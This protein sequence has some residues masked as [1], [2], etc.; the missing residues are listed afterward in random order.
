MKN[1]LKKSLSLLMAVLMILSCWVWVAPE[2]ASAAGTYSVSFDFYVENQATD[3]GHIYLYYHPW[4]ADGSGIDTNQRVKYEGTETNSCF[5]EENKTYVTYD[6]P[7]VDG[8]PCEFF[9]KVNHRAAQDEIVKFLRLRINGKLVADYSGMPWQI[10]DNDGGSETI[11][12]EHTQGDKNNK[13]KEWNTPYFKTLT[14]IDA[15]G[16]TVGKYPN[17]ANVISTVSVTGGTDQYGVE[18]GTGLYPKTGLTYDFYYNDTEGNPVAISSNISGSDLKVTIGRGIQELFP[19][20]SNGKATVYAN[21][22]YNGSKTPVTTDIELNFPTY[23]ASFYPNGGIIGT[24]NVNNTSDDNKPIVIGGEGEDQPNLYYGT[25]IGNAP[26]YAQRAGMT[27]AGYYNIKNDPITGRTGTF[28]GDEFNKGSEYTT[29][30]NTG[31]SHWYAA[32]EASKIRATFMVGDQLLGTLEGR[33]DNS[34]LGKNG[35]MYGTEAQI[36]DELYNA[37][38]EDAKDAIKFDTDKKQPVLY[39]NGQ[40]N[41]FAGWQIIECEYDESQVYKGDLSTILYGDVTFGAKWIPASDITESKYNVTFYN[42]SV[43]NGQPVPMASKTYSYRALV[44]LPT[45]EPTKTQDQKYT[46]E[47]AGWA[48]YIGSPYYAVDANSCTEDGAYIHYTPKEAA[49]FIATKT[50]GYVPVFK[51]TPREYEVT[52]VTFGDGYVQNDNVTVEG[53]HYGDSITVPETIRD[54]YTQAGRRYYIDGWKI[55]NSSTVNNIEDI[56]VTGDMKLTANYDK[57]GVLAEYTIRFFDKD[58]NL[59]GAEYDEEGNLINGSDYIYQH[60]TTVAAP[61]VGDAKE[62]NDT[63]YDIPWTIDTEESRYTFLQWTPTVVTTAGADADYTAEYTQKDYADVYFYNYD[64]KLLCKIDGKEDTNFVDDVIPSY[65]QALP[66]RAED[67]RATYK[68]AGWKDGNGKVVV[69]G[70][71]KFTGDL[72]LTAQFEATDKIYTVLFLNGDEVVSRQELKY[73]E[74]LKEIPATATKAPDDYNSYSFKAWEPAVSEVCYGNATYNATYRKSAIL[75]DISWKAENK[76]EEL[77]HSR[78]AYGIRIQPATAPAESSLLG[79]A[80]VGYIW[81]FK[82][83]VR[84][85]EY[86]TPLE[87][88]VV[89]GK[90]VVRKLDL[91]DAAISAFKEEI[92]TGADAAKIAEINAMSKAEF[93]RFYISSKAIIFKRGMTMPKENL[94]FYPTYELSA[95]KIVVEFF[96]EYGKESFGKATI[97]YNG[98]IDDYAHSFVEDAAKPSDPEYHY[99]FAK[100][101]TLDGAELAQ[102]AD[103]EYI[104]DGTVNKVKVSY[105]KGAHNYVEYETVVAPTCTETGVVTMKCDSPYCDRPTREEILDVIPDDN[106]PDAQVYMGSRKWTMTD[107]ILGKIDY[108]EKIYVGADSA[109]IVNAEDL[110]TISLHNP[111]ATLSRGVGKIDYY[112]SET[113]LDDPATEVSLWNNIYDYSN[114]YNDVLDSV[115][116][117]K[118]YTI[119]DYEDVGFSIDTGVKAEVDKEVKAILATYKANATG[120][121]GELGLENGKEYIIYLRVSDREYNGDV[122]IS[123]LSTGRLHYGTQAATITVSGDGY[124]SK[125]CEEATVRIADDTDGFEVYLDGEYQEGVK[126]SGLSLSGVYSATFRTAEVGVHTVTVVDKNGNRSSKT[127]EIKGGHTFRNYTVAASCENDGSRYDLCTVC[128]VKDNE[129]VLTKLGHNYKSFTEKAPSCTVYGYR[130][131]VC[132]NNCGGKLIVSYDT[133]AKSWTNLAEAKLTAADVKHLEATGEHTYPM[134]IDEDGKET[135]EAAWVIDKAATC[136]AEGA[137]HRDCTKCGY[138]NSVTIAID[139]NAHKFYRPRVEK[140]DEPTCTTGGIR[141]ETC[142]YCGEKNTVEKLDPLGHTAGEYK[143]TLEATCTAAGSK[144]LTC[145]VCKAEIG[146]QHED[147][148]GKVT[149][150]GKAVEIPALGHKMQAQDAPYQKTGEEADGKWYQK[151]VCANGCGHVEEKETAYQ[152]QKKATVKFVNEDGTTVVDTIEKVVGETIIA[153][154]VTAPTK[155][156]DETYKYTFSHWA[157]TDGKEVSFPITVAE[158]GATYKAVFAKKNVKYTVTY[159][160]DDGTQYKKVGY[161]NNDTEVKLVEGPAK[162]ETATHTFTFNGWAKKVET[163]VTEEVED[164]EGNLTT[165]TKTVITYEPVGDKVTIND[166]SVVLYATYTPVTKVYKVTY[167]YS[168]SDTI[169]T[170]FANAGSP[171]PACGLKP[172]KKADSKN[173]YEFASWNRDLAEVT[174]NIYTTPNFSAEEHD[175]EVVTVTP[176]TCTSYAV[177][178][179]VCKICKYETATYEDKSVTIGHNWSEKAD[180]D[181]ETG[182]YIRR[183]QNEGC[184]A[185]TA[186]TRTFTFDFYKEEPADENVRPYIDVVNIAWGTKVDASRLPAAP[187]KDADDQYIYTFKGWKLKGDATNTIVDIEKLEVKQD[188]D[189]VA[190][191]DKAVREYTVT[192]AYEYSHKPIKMYTV[193]YGEPVVFD[194]ATP[195]KEKDTD[196]NYDPENYHYTFKGWSAKTDKITAETIVYAK[197]TKAEHTY[198]TAVE[199]GPA[200]CQQGTGYKYTCTLDTCKHVK[201]ETGKPLAH[202]LEIIENVAATPDKDG[203]IKRQ[204]A[205]EYDGKRCEYTETEVLKYEDSTV[206]VIVTVDRDGKPASNIKVLTHAIGEDATM[207]ASTNVNGIATIVVEKDKTYVAYVEIDGNKIPVT[208]VADSSGNFIGVYSIITNN[209]GNSGDADCGCACHRNNFWG[210]IFRFFHKIIKLFTGEFKCCGNPDPMYG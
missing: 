202:K 88:V 84:C 150:D 50:V 146:E 184:T 171:A 58:G 10:G 159:L 149:F 33:Y 39:I 167:A 55:G 168:I 158:E 37:Y 157:D 1:Q 19:N 61:S 166:E 74:H 68:F 156:A 36:N 194:G 82:E 34:M 103:G 99:D 31:D 7:A 30:S 118:G 111:L 139:K 66:E 190:V 77:R 148:N 186:D 147:E 131:Y 98:V 96:D 188:Y 42:G 208:L 162:A 128:G 130:T 83:W 196:P 117:D 182:K 80:P 91:S 151:Y 177:V 57:G 143:V 112:V 23:T 191:F 132:D 180:Y 210:T 141:T 201:Y 106:A 8:F 49:E 67:V 110:G 100:W 102:N 205:Y 27:F 72:H 115:L 206:R 134:V 137:K 154:D 95:T 185:T 87:M 40:K 64:G 140:G 65:P 200:T 124:G 73:G 38:K 142:R 121:L 76:T 4:K 169:V 35:N 92:L 90:E 85:D 21:A 70:S 48:E 116:K 69:P 183:C 78:Y 5:R 17:G 113:V 6:I 15:T 52:F 59:I 86:G 79:G 22:Y 43:N 81:A 93:E 9:V 105:T 161:I 20:P 46:Y 25:P 53:Y 123:Y 164:A 114:V 203:Y 195:V 62:G 136:I 179:K 54:N 101:V 165:T 144:I 126:A 94:Y 45:R 207:D 122:N 97:P 153:T 2:K 104:I 24:S 135:T 155:A 14:S 204:C 125:F 51:M 176:A 75:Y 138:R 108:N 26:A 60:G 41:V 172:E 187:E 189:F 209:N 199:T 192:F 175:F 152:E 63:T 163:I 197:F 145:A 18:C 16:V 133:E 178:K 29:V 56:T 47:F 44:N 174:S 119:E 129:Q 71:D 109:T 173:H 11:T 32:W 120:M 127:F 28:I 107:Y 3:G 193:K 89:D 160:N 13:V 181:D 12:R 198:G 170:V